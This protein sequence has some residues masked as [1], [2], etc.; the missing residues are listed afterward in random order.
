MKSI[1]LDQLKTMLKSM[2]YPIFTRIGRAEKNVQSLTDKVSD[3]K[4]QISAKPQKI[5]FRENSSNEYTCDL[6]F[7]ALWAM[8][9]EQIANNTILIDS[10]GIEKAAR[11][12]RK[13]GSFGYGIRNIQID[14]DGRFESDMVTYFKPT[15]IIDWWAHGDVST[16]N[17]HTASSLS[18]QKIGAID[19]PNVP[20]LR[21]ANWENYKVGRG[22]KVDASASVLGINAGEGLEVVGD[23]LR[24]KPEGEYEL[25]DIIVLGYERLTEKPEDWE[26]NWSTYYETTEGL[27]KAVA[28][29]RVWKPWRYFKTAEYEPVS[30]IEVNKEPD[31]T[32]Y[33]FKKMYIDLTT[34]QSD[35]KKV[36][37][38]NV[39]QR[40]ILYNA[41]MLDTAG[42]TTGA[43]TKVF[44][45]IDG[46]IF[47]NR[48]IAGGLAGGL[49]WANANQYLAGFAILNQSD[50]NYMNVTLLNGVTFPEGTVLKI[51][52]VRNNA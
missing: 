37:V 16:I 23:E 43:G 21:G 5:I 46:G 38:V 35:S 18:N 8:E 42:A 49:G 15:V 30:K 29:Y 13:G 27:L 1:S 47:T 11:S 22:L 34:P 26:T 32:P 19:V 9:P 40:S 41:A 17:V 31:G 50:I 10:Y 14:I 25:I 39:N 36:G 33:N 20:I 44:C 4:T 12:A 45:E 3:L 6:T 24:V 51:Y 7:D 28:S 2:S 52:G 48:A